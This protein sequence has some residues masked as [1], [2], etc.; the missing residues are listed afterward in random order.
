MNFTAK[1]FAAFAASLAYAEQVLDPEAGQCLAGSTADSCL[2]TA[3]VGNSHFE[4]L[5]SMFEWHKSVGGRL[6]K[7]YMHT[8]P[9]E[10]DNSEMRASDDIQRD[11]LVAFIPEEMLLTVTHAKENSPMVKVLIENGVLD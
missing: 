5:Q 11:E 6:D 4:H 3:D 7:V 9:G 10:N 1:I 8:V 2:A